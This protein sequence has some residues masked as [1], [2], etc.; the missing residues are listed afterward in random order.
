M[1][2]TLVEKGVGSLLQPWH[3]VRM[4]K[5]AAEVRRAEILLLAQAERDA[6]DLR[7]GRKTLNAH[8]R[9]VGVGY[10]GETSDESDSGLV[11][12]EPV[13]SVEQAVA[14]SAAL[15]AADKVRCEINNSRAIIYAEQELLTDNGLPPQEVVEDDWL[16]VWKEYSSKVS[17]EGLQ[18]LWG[19]V[20]AGEVKSPGKYSVRTLEFL[21]L[22]S[23]FEA[24][25][26]AKV[27]RYG[28]GGIIP[29]ELLDHMW[30]QGL[31]YG[32]LM[33]LETIGVLQGL[34][35]FGL[36]KNYVSVKEERFAAVLNSH[37]RCLLV[38]HD[39]PQKKLSLEI[40]SFTHVGVQLLDLGKFE[41]DET[42]LRALG[43]KVA[44][45]GFK[46]S[47]CDWEQ[48]TETQGACVNKE[49]ISLGN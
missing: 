30:E 38:E 28:I 25:L 32:Q 23:K 1:W 13:I 29:K 37:G 44:E 24:E 3:T 9:L 2:E 45:K 21:K 4:G 14:K 19:S 47:I 18:R 20:L 35:A 17:V 43:A 11:R 49:I 7:A 36:E 42:Y 6:D 41:H 31:T 27:A 16:Y 12:I 8:G 5:A 15:E 34:D 46:V 26:I 10:E 33:H 22:L 48:V 39:D 40:C